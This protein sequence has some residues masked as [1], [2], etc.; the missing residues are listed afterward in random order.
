MERHIYAR[1]RDSGHRE[2]PRRQREMTKQCKLMP[3]TLAL[4]LCLSEFPPLFL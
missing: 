2:L 4:L 3:A 1:Q